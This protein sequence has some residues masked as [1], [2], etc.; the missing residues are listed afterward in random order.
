VRFGIGV[1]AL[2]TAL[3]ALLPRL[4][5]SRAP[6]MKISA[7]ATIRLPDRPNLLLA[8]VHTDDGLVGLGETPRGAL[9]IE[10]QIHDLVAP[11]LLGK[12]PLTSVGKSGLA[13]MSDPKHEHPV[14]CGV[15]PIHRDESRTPM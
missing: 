9:A 5:R 14:L 13:L 6:R 2:V 12:D 15:K 3:S 11:Y 7:I 4:G 8:Q 1:A 10:G